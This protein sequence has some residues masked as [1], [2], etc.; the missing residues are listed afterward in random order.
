M[1]SMGFREHTTL[2]SGSIRY[3]LRRATG[4]LAGFKMMLSSS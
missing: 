3:F 2:A 4:K 1:N